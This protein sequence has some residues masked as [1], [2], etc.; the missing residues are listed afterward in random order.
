MYLIRERF[1]DLGDDFDIT[2]D[3]GRAIFHVDGKVFSLRNRLVIEDT[4]GREVAAVHRHLVSLRPTYEIT[5]AGEKAAE[6]RKSLFGS[7]LIKLG[8]WLRTAGCRA[9]GSGVRRL[10]DQPV[11]HRE[12]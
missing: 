3:S 10:V 7:M 5:I 6:V 1:F 12:P 4:A 8:S 9:G 11:R 2:D